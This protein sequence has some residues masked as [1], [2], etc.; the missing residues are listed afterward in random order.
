MENLTIMGVTPMEMPD[1]FLSKALF[2]K[3]IFP[4]LSLGRDIDQAV[5]ALTQLVK[6]THH[7]FG[8]SFVSNKMTSIQLPEQV[9]LAIVPWGM[10]IELNPSIKVF[11]QVHSLD[12]AIEAKASGASQII[13]KG[14]ESGGH[15]GNDST[16][17]LF[18]KIKKEL[19]EMDVWVQ[20]GLG[21]HTSAAVMALGAKGVVLDSQLILF[22]ECRLPKEIKSVCEKLNGNETVIIDNYRVL[23]RPNSPELPESATLE[24][25]EPYLGTTNIAEGYFP[26]G[27][28]IAISTDLAKRYKKLQNLAFSIREAISGH[29]RQAQ[30]I[31]VVRQGNALAQDLGITYPIAQ[32]PM[33]RV[34]DVPEFAASVADAGALPFIALS[35]IRGEKAKTLIQETKQKAGDN[36]WGVGIL[37]FAP[38]E[39]REEQTNYILEEKPPVVLIAGGRPSQ[40]KPFEKAGI[41]TFLHVPSTSLLD[42]FIKEGARK[43]VFEGRECGGHVGPLSSFILWERQINR[44]LEEDNPEQFSIFFAG[45]IHD[46]Y[47]SALISVMAAPLAAKGM[48]VGVLIGTAYLYTQEAVNSGAILEQ[49]QQEA[50]KQKKTVLLETAP[51]HETRCLNSPFVDF[52]NDE[53]HKLT[54]G[55]VD[56]KEIWARLET[57][58]VGR[59]RIAAKGIERQGEELVTI[60][61]KEQFN[62]GMY[63][64]GQ[65]AALRSEVVTMRDLHI[66]VAE[67]CYQHI[68]E[69]TPM[70]LPET[71]EKSLDVAIVGMACIYPDAKNIDEFWRNIL[72]GKDVVTEVPDERWNKEL[73]YD[74]ESSN[75][76]KTPSKWGGFIPKIDFD[77]LEFG[78]PPQS[79]AAIEP[80]QILSL[81]VAKQA[82][83]NAGYTPGEFDS[84][85]VSVIVGAEGGNDLANSY[86][87]RSMF[88]QVLGEMP[89]ELANSLPKLTEDSFP[90]VLANV[91]SGRITNRLNLGGRNYTVDAACAS[92][93][94][95]VDLACQE[96]VSDRSDMVLAGGVDLH[97]GINDYLMFSSTHALSRKGKCFTFDSEA[98]G[99]ALGEGAAMVVLKRHEDAIRDGDKV[100][101]VLKGIGG[102]SDGKSLGLTAPR[103]TGQMKALERAYQQAGVSISSVGLIEAHGTGT[104]VGD[105]TELSALTDAMI[106]SGGTTGQAHLGSVKTQIGHTKCAAGLA[107]LIKAALSVYH[108]VKPPTINITKPNDFYN[109]DTSPFLFN[110][111]AGLWNEEKRRAGISAFGFGGTNFHAV[112]ENA[113]TTEE[114]ESVIQSWPSELFVFRGKSL[115]EAKEVLRNTKNLLSLNDSIDLKDLAYS[116][117]TTDDQP[118]QVT[119]VASGTNDLISKVENA[120]TDKETKDVWVTNPVDGKVAFL[121]PGQGSQRINMARDLLVMFPEMR[122]KLAENPPLESVIFPSSVFDNQTAQQQKAAIKDTRIAQPA[123]GVIDLAIARFLEK[124]GITPDMVAG[125]S[126][127]ELP[128]LCFSGVFQEED[129]VNLSQMRAKAILDAVGDDPGTMLAV[130]CESTRLETLL[131]DEKDV[132]L[133][134]INSPKQLV[135]AG[136][137]EA[138]STF[139]EKLKKEGVSCKRLEVACAFHSPLLAR[140]KSLY[141]KAIAKVPFNKPAVP[142]WSNT[143]TLLYPEEPREIKKRL[144][145]HLVEP[146]QFVT[147]IQN[148]YEDGARVFIEVG[149]GKVLSSLTK[150]ILGKD[151]LL[152]QTEDTVDHGLTNLLRGLA[153]YL[154]SGRSI[155]LEKLFEGRKTTKLE[156]DKP[157]LYEKKPTIWSV[158]GQMSIPLKGQLP[159]HGALPITEPLKLVGA[160]SNTPLIV[161]DGSTEHLVQEY[162][163]GMKSMIQAQRDVM[164]GFLGKPIDI[165]APVSSETTKPLPIITQQTSEIQSASSPAS[166]Q[167]TE[168]EVNDMLMKVITEKTGYPLEMLGEN[169]DLEADL[170]ID[171]IKR[172]EIIGELKDMLGG[173]SSAETNEEAIV[174]ELAGIKTVKGL[175]SWIVEN[176]LKHMGEV[177]AVESAATTA[178]VLNEEEIRNT[179]LKTVSEKTG[180]PIDMIGL[181]MDLEA[182]LS[183]DSI[184]R[185]EIIG[186]LR[187]LLGGFGSTQENEEAIV[188]ELAGIKTVRGLASWI[189]EHAARQTTSAIPVTEPDITKSQ[190]N[191]LTAEN[192]KEILLK[193]VSEKT[194]YP[195]DMLGMDMD[196]E[197]DLSIDSIKRLEIIGDLKDMLGGFNTTQEEEEAV[198]EELASIKT[199]NGLMSWLMEKLT[200]DTPTEPVNELVSEEDSLVEKEEE[201]LARFRFELT[202]SGLEKTSRSSLQGEHFAIMDDGGE[203][204]PA[205]KKRLEEYGAEADII[206]ESDQLNGHSGFVALDLISA[207]GSF[208]VLNFFSLIKKLDL[209]KVKWVYAVSDLKSHIQTPEDITL[210]RNL[211]GYSGFLKSLDKEYEHLNCKKISLSARL[212]VKDI[213]TLVLDEILHTDTH[214]EVTY[215]DHGRQSM[216]MIQEPLINGQES[217]IQL[218]KESVIL[219]LGGARGI[220]AELMIELSKEYP[221]HY[222]LV[223]RSPEPI[224]DKN[225]GL[226]ALKTKDEIRKAIIASGQFKTPAEIEK[227]TQTVFKN[228]EIFSTIHGFEANGATVTYHSLDLRDEKAMTK[229]IEDLY[230]KH[231]R[232]DGV[233]HGAGL[234]EDKLFRQKTMESFERV[235]STKVTP[236]RV[237]AEH[238]RSDVQFIA[239]FSSVASVYGNRGQ[240]DY[241]AANN[242]M[243]FYAW[244]LKNKFSGKVTAINWGPWKGTGMV[245]PELAKEYE[246]RGIPLI[247]LEAGKQLFLNE[248]KYGKESQVLIMAGESGFFG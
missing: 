51:G 136:K 25:L 195:T 24:D 114:K 115:D 228:N 38:P 240:T 194:G 229:L 116:L 34:S 235:F 213:A 175:A 55:G 129:I 180:Y 233:V 221:C 242:V 214:P 52:F 49:F 113:D 222:L 37:G 189:G 14:N 167:L 45:G 15:V 151:E 26:I 211:K 4:V 162:L 161:N 207:S 33:T 40:A 150:A 48:K 246:R 41:K 232:I 86:G 112:I 50:I 97:N 163:N 126:Y 89:E 64:I 77:P 12:E 99:I 21:I 39:L 9:K 85:N 191:T 3:K 107:G 192:I 202:P 156:L 154:S 65:V 74:P 230:K 219:V 149:P 234:L 177:P 166:T 193:S 153:K 125:H 23:K 220:T 238:L 81:L 96:L 71:S 248:L 176:A 123:L 158:N 216:S 88:P 172:M 5:T 184:K 13:A 22:P 140:A 54:Q 73:Y 98:D 92:S 19:P 217:Q 6:S 28:D 53:K 7:S 90:G 79:L 199:L 237:L 57:L 137:T 147:E 84:E 190:A 181:D 103:K 91:I 132:H 108:G 20:G 138:I 148:M 56:K 111:K 173:F 210:L 47:S 93:L 231:Q 171:S 135:V 121:F 95:A 87:F 66:D 35:L 155:Q 143:T 17:I 215:F 146:V 247:P 82:L 62:N 44:L 201:P 127:G 61:K 72:M 164:L 32:G 134:N 78:I 203:V 168:K 159:K 139:H 179:L 36:T 76:E 174:E 8:V 83:V 204:A 206:S 218:E 152:V 58:N 178:V 2:E 94:A 105:K 236:M 197:A 100:Y 185:M 188:E 68:E 142:V 10:S 157:E 16:F 198:V 1:V 160:A 141:E 245:S 205:I 124:L 109:P 69:A 120:L 209:E 70:G 11:Y 133:V 243:D 59:L 110:M 117:A 225:E 212:E 119:I 31:D 42:M 101:A 170:S 43:F 196:L 104:V 223:G 227:K 224:P 169:M 122:Q 200:S 241:A 29:L 239:L 67:T 46:S 18:Q 30:S 226:N 118:I 182:D 102:S 27:Q 244:E 128:A 186:E 80:S 106:N 187:D 165:T 60:D 130:N 131:T 183:I 75:G 145:D 63:M 144:G 208:D